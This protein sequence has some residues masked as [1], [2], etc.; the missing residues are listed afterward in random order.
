MRLRKKEKK[1]IITKERD[2]KL[3]AKGMKTIM[4]FFNQCITTYH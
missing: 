2:Q 4:N 1:Y 3:L